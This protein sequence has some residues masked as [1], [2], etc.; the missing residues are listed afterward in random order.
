MLKHTSNAIKKGWGLGIAMLLLGS[1]PASAQSCASPANA[2]VAEN[3]LTGN[4]E[5]EWQVSGFGDGTIQGYATEMSVNRG[6]TVSFKVKTDASNYR[7]DIY[8][9]GYYNGNG[10]RKIATVNPSVSLPQ[11]QPACVSEPST[12]LIDCGNWT[13]SASW[14]IPATAVSG[15]YIGRLVRTDNGGASHIMFVVRNDNG[16]ADVL[17][18]TSDTTWQA[19][20]DYG[21]NSL[22]YGAPV[23]R[24][25]KVSYNRPFATGNTVVGYGQHTWWVVNE[26][27]MIRWLERNGYNVSYSSGIETDRGASEL[28]KHKIFVSSGHDEYWSGAQRANVEAARDAGLHLAFF[29]GNE[30]FWKT[31]WE[32]SIAGASTPYR[33]LVAYKETYLGTKIDPTSTWTGTWRDP[34]LSPPSDGG[35]PENALTGTRFMVN[36]CEG[37]S[38]QVPAA[39]GKLRFWRNTD[40]ANLTAG[41]V[42]STTSGVIGFESDEAPDDE[43]TP[44]G[45]VRLSTTT[46]LINGGYLQDYGTSYGVSNATHSLV[47]HKRPSGALVFASGTVRWSWGLDGG[48][49]RDGSSVEDPNMQQATVNL[50]ADMG[51]QPGSLQATLVSATASSD[52]TRPSSSITSPAG[53]SSVSGTVTIT[54]TASDVGG[55]VSG[56]HVSFDGGATWKLA[57]GTT[58]WSYTWN[59]GASGP[60]NLKSRAVDDSGNIESPAAGITVNGS[61]PACPCSIWSASTV[62]SVPAVSEA[63]AIELGVKFRVGQNG[64]ITGIRFYKGSGNTGTHIGNLWT[65]AGANLA[66]ATFSGE[67]ATGWQQVNF[68]SPVAVN[69]NTTYIAS[70]YTPTGHYANTAGFF[71]TGGVTNGALRAL[72]TGEDGGNGVF[73]YGTG[74]GFPT[75]FY[76]S[77]NYWVDVVYTTTNSGGSPGAVADIY[78]GTSGQVLTIGAP[79]LLSNDTSP[80]NLALTAIKVTNPANGTV[81]VNPNGGFTYTPNAGFVGTDSFTY[82]ANNGT[83]DSN[84][85]TVTL[86]ACTLWSSSVVPTN[87]AAPESSTVE[88]G[89]KFRASQSGYI[90]GIRFYKGTGNTGTHIGNLWSSTGTNLATA[91]FSNET[92]TGWQQVLFTTPVAIA[93]NTTYVASYYAPVGR[94]AYDPAY[95]N[96]GLVNGP[97]RGLANGEDGANGVYL[98][99]TGGGFPTS[100]YNSTNYWVDVVF[101]TSIGNQAPVATAD[102]YAT[103][104]NTPLTVAAAGVLGNDSDPDS[105]PLT[106]IKVTNP[107]NGSVTLNSNGSFTYTPNAAFTGNDTFTYKAN[108]G[109]VDSNT[110]SVSISVNPLPTATNDSYSTAQGQALTVSAPGV[111]GNDNSP[112]GFAL[113]AIKVTD[114]AN[115]TVTLNA[116]GSF[117]Y[118][119]NSGF[120]GSNNFTYKAHN[121]TGDSNVATVTITVNAVPVATGDSYS[122]SSGQP[123]TV[124]APG[125]LGNDT[126]PGGLP[127]TAI[128]VTNPANGVVTL[129]TNGSFTYTPNGGFAGT[130]SFTYKA[131]NGAVDSNTATVTITVLAIPVANNDSYSASLNTPLTVSAPGVLG[132]DSGASLTAIKVTNPANGTV[133]LSA[134]GGFTFT[135]TTG[136]TGSTSFTYKANNG[137]MDSNVAT[138]TINVTTAPIAGN[139]S[140]SA[141]TAVA[142]TVTAPGLL[143]NDSGGALTAIKVT[144]PTSGTVT[145]NS[146]GGFTYTSNAGFTGNDSFTYKANNGT[147]DS[148]I[149]TVTIAVNSAPVAVADIYSGTS[150]LPLTIG[151][152]GLLS[153]DTSPGGIALTAIKVTNPTNGTVT[154]NPN[155][156][157]TYTPNAG[158]VGTDSFTYKANNGMVDSNTVTVTLC[159]CTIWNS[160]T[161][162]ANAAAPDPNPVELGVKFRATQAGY[163][164]GIRFY[165]GTGNTGTHIGN[166]WSSTGTNLATATFT[167]ETATGWQQ[168]LFATP[169]A[170]TAN[171]TYIASYFAPVGRYAYDPAYFGSAVIN[172]PLRGLGNSEDGGN[173]VYFYG[174]ASGFPNSN[175][176]STNYWVD[177]VFVTSIGNQAPVS[178][179]DTYA[180]AQSTPL[181]VA[182]PGVLSN[183]SDPDGNPLTAVK[184]TNPTSGSV[185]L[186]SNGSFTYSPNAGF[187]GTDTFTYKANDGTV[188][189][190]IVTVTINVNALPT[191]SNDA[192]SVNQGQAL[193]VTAPGVLGNDNSPGG[194]TLTMIRLTDPANGSVTSNAN[195]SFTY[196]PTAGFIGTNSFTYR[197]H[198]STG[199]SNIATVTITVNAVPV[200]T[201]DSYSVSSGQ[202]ITVSAPGLLGNDS[203][204]GGLPLTASKVAN[205]A[206]GV[207]TVNSNGSFTYTPNAGFAGTDT[208]TYKANNGINDSNTATV[209]ITVFAIPLASNDSYSGSL[210]TPL[211]VAAPGVLGNDAGASLTAIKVSDPANGSV[212]LSANGGFT[213]TPTTGFTGSTS[214]TYKANNGLMDS[215]VAT[216]TISVTN[217]PVA[218]NDAYNATTAIALT[219]AAPGL[220][221]NDSGGTLTAI[222]LTNPANG[223]VTVNSNGSFTYTSNAGFTGTNTFTYKANNGTTDSNIATVTITVLA[224]PTAV[225]DIYSGTSGS[226]ITISAPGLLSNDISPGGIALTAIKVANPT[227]GSVTVNPNG[228]FTYTPNAGFVGTDSF[229]YKANNGMVDSNTVTVTLC[230]CTIWN[231]NTV[232]GN[233]AAPDPSTIELGVKFRATQSGYIK[234]IRF[235]KGAGNTGTHIGN[236]WSSTGTNLATATFSNETATGW[237][238][239]LFA[240]PVAVTANTTYVA[241]YYAPVGHY[242]YDL[243][244]FGSAVVNGPLRALANGE[245]G[246]NGVFLYAA[247]GGF[248]N[249]TYNSNNYWVDVVF[250]TIP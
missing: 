27:P 33:T 161:V 69:A 185:T 74:G 237:Q 210:N 44:A 131:N 84:I 45:L 49:H 232:P 121:S 208:F 79:G 55:Q 7:I 206:N 213:F 111:L 29:S 43:F 2:V 61:I 202:P 70:Y 60:L 134:N 68:P 35:R 215:N 116:N 127:L 22:Y 41:Q 196:T 211:T 21:G 193:T 171:T 76:G 180:T 81:T 65:S 144:N 243:A 159:A 90:K 174:S 108:D 75:D 219:V 93:A 107:A 244:F 30:V 139:D 1:L 16:F 209:T 57:N 123:M 56:V 177:L 240:T 173:G 148:N 106:A 40:F 104:Q 132:N 178:A 245:D 141:T 101:V 103:A 218:T 92:A 47:L 86:C 147:T 176:N 224:V 37:I 42:G 20:N 98:Y 203:S 124:S 197:A 64:Y 246:G 119:P 26:Y 53:G 32:N 25:Y 100:F 235:Y 216:V 199:D 145:V 13:V 204:P 160:N 143:A 250:S 175:Y 179:P 162:P 190:A 52:S 122:V 241:S 227:N 201:G 23:G 15:L 157:F 137:L 6:S 182:A 88:L 18:Q 115:G 138:V 66:T 151:A 146:N 154:V 169:V 9:V 12:G 133:T 165:K 71:A 189:S 129:N 221:G 50:F 99:A 166:L 87:A 34:R 10:A 220:L 36:C 105:N 125:V 95:F 126:S 19:Y 234:G 39:Q 109:A 140:Y 4:P 14:A 217:A 130:D 114:P 222:K 118:T 149:A 142:L 96:T 117:T 192:Y 63:A 28:L 158:F 229:T 226:P 194:F 62:P 54:G 191:A 200:A 181:T 128:K 80:G 187:I 247:G 85:A 230:A 77:G 225:A 89:V 238:E 198:N 155:G 248:P 233:A 94:Y 91:T 24:A 73:R 113:T 72:A 58:S 97:L 83:I 150:G 242:A 78:S 188:D 184:V 239:V 183:D 59:V 205:P 110:V 249:A 120:T 214:F 170:V 5:S 223:T 236:L 186:N 31:R 167:G 48:D 163:I 102:T 207:A 11:T 195:G 164:R 112:G 8:R 231:S 82:K 228:G 152:P 67:T 17:Y 51:V 153:N 3:C 136:F 46:R 135:P 172:G 38:I 212:T 168:V 156:G